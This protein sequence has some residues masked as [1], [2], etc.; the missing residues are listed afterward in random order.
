MFCGRLGECEAL[1]RPLTVKDALECAEVRALA[2]RY[3][4]LAKDAYSEFS[5]TRSP[6]PVNGMFP[7]DA[8]IVAPFL[9]AMEKKL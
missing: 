5:N 7:N 9:A 2:L 1:C 3:L 6:N 4:L 8:E